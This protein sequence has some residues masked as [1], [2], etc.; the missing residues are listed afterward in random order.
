MALIYLF[1]F[2]ANGGSV[3][4]AMFIAAYK[5]GWLSIACAVLGGYLCIGAIVIG[6]LGVIVLSLLKR[7]RTPEDNIGQT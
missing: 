7:E 6:S 1:F 2:M 3:I 4:L 5:L